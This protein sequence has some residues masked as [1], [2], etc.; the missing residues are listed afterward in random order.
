VRYGSKADV[1]IRDGRTSHF[2]FF[3]I[4]NNTFVSAPSMEQVGAKRSVAGI[5]PIDWR[6]ARKCAAWTARP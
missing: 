4:S 2:E 3:H 5:A 6:G 1:L